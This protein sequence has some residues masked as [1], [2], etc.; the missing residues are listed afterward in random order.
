MTETTSTGDIQAGIANVGGTQHIYGNVTVYFGASARPVET[1]PIT[2][3]RLFLSYG[4]GDDDP[5]YQDGAKSFMRRL[6]TDLTAAGYEVWWD[7]ESMPSRG[8]TFLQE[9]RD[10]ITTS[11]RVLLVVGPYGMQSDYVRAEWDYALSHCIPIIPLL[12]SGSYG[13]IPSEISQFHAPDFRDDARYD[14]SLNELKRLLETAESPLGALYGIPTLPAN[15]IRREAFADLQKSVLTD[16][17]KPIVVTAQQQITTLHGLGGIGKTTL[18]AALARSCEVRRAFPDGVFWLDI[19]KQPDVVARMGDVAAALGLPRSEFPTDLNS[20]VFVFAELLRNKRAFLILDDVWH[21]QHVEPFR[22]SDTLSRL[23]IT[24]RQAGIAARLQGQAQALNTLSPAEGEMLLKAQS[25][26]ASSTVLASI[27]RL[28]GGHTLAVQLAAAWLAER[29]GDAEDLLRRLE[30]G[31]VF[32]DL[33][34]AEDDRQQNLELCLRLSYEALNGDLQ[35]R[36]RATGIFA[37]EGSIDGFVAASVWVDEDADDSADRLADLARA[38]L[39]LRSPEGRYTRHGLMRAYT[40]ALLTEAGEIDEAFGRYADHIIRTAKLF[41]EL[42]L[43]EWSA[44]DPLIPHVRYVGDELTR[45]WT[46][47]TSDVTLLR[48]C[49]DFAYSVT[50]FVNNRPQMVETAHG[51]ERMGLRWLEIGLEASRKLE[52]KR[53]ESLFANQLGGL[54]W[55]EGEV[56][57]ALEYYL[58]ALDLDREAGDQHGEAVMLSNIGLVWAERGDTQ[59]ALHYY[60]TSMK[61]REGIKD[62]A[63]AAVTLNNMGSLR[64][65]TG[66]LHGALEYFHHALRILEIY[67]NPVNKAST[68]ENIAISWKALGNYQKAFEYLGPALELRRAIG[69]PG[70]EATTL[71]ILGSIWSALGDYAK[72]VEYTEQALPLQ[73]SA[74]DRRG[75][76]N[77]LTNLGALCYRTGDLEKALGYLEQALPLHRRMG[78]RDGESSALNALSGIYNQRDDVERALYFQYQTVGIAQE[79]GAPAKEASYWLSIAVLHKRVGRIE[80]ALEAAQAGKALLIHHQLPQNASGNRIEVY[81][82]LIAEL[83][84]AAGL[85]GFAL[86]VETIQQFAQNTYTVATSRPDK[87]EEWQSIL[88]EHEQNWRERGWKY[89]AAFGQALLNILNG[90]KPVLPEHHP[91]QDVVRQIVDGLNRHRG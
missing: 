90:E 80:P 23:L 82:S 41:D 83:Q 33:K 54:W 5:D 75:E 14:S 37:S 2:D 15:Y 67:E 40:L 39:L 86:E 32:K 68:L 30:K 87:R 4:R 73:R 61:L 26:A 6:Y 84:Q 56:D 89:E 10:A 91:Y 29:G 57:Q 3:R 42:P 58:R 22:V 52:N 21:P 34:L 78:N 8:L 63:G 53:L 71:A 47:D 13:L 27:V 81:D 72:A 17:E 50:R 77:T 18:A 11:A 1:A 19:G 12:R 9:I 7:R 46:P 51:M 70:S 43:E 88:L 85:P 74:G 25:P 76:A 44:L 20:A 48:R 60:E 35:R 62:Y 59:R 24:T 69:D 66:D 28:L 79:L 65:T 31:R 16:I 45:R 49:S 64:N 55:E 36:F 38:G